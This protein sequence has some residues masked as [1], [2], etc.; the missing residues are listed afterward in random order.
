VSCVVAH[1]RGVSVG[2]NKTVR[3][4]LLVMGHDTV[5]APDLSVVQCAAVARTP[6]C[7]RDAMCA[8]R[9]IFFTHQ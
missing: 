9:L 8:A 3:R 6:P 7:R 5:C 2:L 1:V 4:N